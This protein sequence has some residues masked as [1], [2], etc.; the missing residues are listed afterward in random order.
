[1]YMLD[2]VLGSSRLSC[3]V[4]TESAETAEDDA[5]AATASS[6]SSSS[7][8]VLSTSTPAPVTPG[9]NTNLYITGLP[10]AYST[11][12]VEALFGQFGRIISARI[13]LNVLTGLSRGI[14][15][16]RFEQLE[17]CNAAIEALNN[18][19]RKQQYNTTTTIYTH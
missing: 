17:P 18:K 19:T 2:I 3:V 12:D 13:L 4:K 9:V 7:S 1:M 10:I 14:A 11:H 15:M 8:S 6:A 5:A 16:V